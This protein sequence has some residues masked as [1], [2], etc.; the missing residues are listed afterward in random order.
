MEAGR[1]DAAR[2][3]PNCPND[4]VSGVWAF[5]RVLVAPEWSSRQSHALPTVNAYFIVECPSSPYL[6]RTTTSTPMSIP[7]SERPLNFVLV[8]GAWHGGWCWKRVSPLLRELGHEVFT[9]TL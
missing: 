9:P 1:R 4:T 7:R 2:H 6:K 5:L 3:L 8:H